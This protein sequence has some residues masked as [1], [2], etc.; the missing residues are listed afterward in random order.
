M[1]KKREKLEFEVPKKGEKLEFEVLKP[2]EKLEFE[3]P[4][5]RK[6]GLSWRAKTG[7]SIALIAVISVV[8]LFLWT[9]YYPKTSGVITNAQLSSSTVQEGEIPIISVTVNN[10]GNKDATFQVD[11]ISSSGTT[12]KQK[13]IS[14]GESGTLILNLTPS[15]NDTSVTL[16]LYADGTF[17]DTRTLPITVTYVDLE[18]TYSLTGGWS[19]GID[20]LPAYTV[21][22]SFTVKNN[23]TA[24]ANNINLTAVIDGT[25]STSLGSVSSLTAGGTHSDSVS[26]TLEEGSHSIKIRAAST[27][28]T[29]TS[30]SKSFNASLPRRPYQQEEIMK[31]YITPND[32]V[33]VSTANSI[34]EN[35]PWWDILSADWQLIRD[36]VKNN[37]MYEYDSVQ[38]GVSEYWQLPRETLARGKG[39]CE[40]QAILLASLLRARGFGS[41]SVYVIAGYGEDTGHAWVT[42]KVFEINILGYEWEY[43][44][45]LEPTRGGFLSGFNDFLNQIFGTYE[46]NYGSDRIMFNDV[47]YQT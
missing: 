10:T 28:D 38:F 24:T 43:W 41:D 18:V 6:G 31:L 7:I 37:I 15:R 8:A 11:L 32:S 22:G 29:S 16:K 5:I 40:D 14:A 39:D 46:A 23:G 33:V 26:I 17:L 45:Y 44:R 12:S 35:K 2:K 3:F 47:S 30:A 9:W 25:T 13:T 21:S 36:W 34:I 42:F 19:R 20:G 4:K 1:K 27:S